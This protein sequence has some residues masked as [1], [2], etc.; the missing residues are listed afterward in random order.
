LYIFFLI[1]FLEFIFVFYWR[2]HHHW[3]Y[4]GHSFNIDIL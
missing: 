2:S 1:D 3:R 4:S